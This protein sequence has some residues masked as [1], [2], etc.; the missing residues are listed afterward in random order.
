MATSFGLKREYTTTSSVLITEIFN[1]LLQHQKV[2]ID[3]IFKIVL[4]DSGMIVP[5]QFI[6]IHTNY[7]ELRKKFQKNVTFV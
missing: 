5:H 6:S 1:D 2:L 7:L 4:Q 3:K